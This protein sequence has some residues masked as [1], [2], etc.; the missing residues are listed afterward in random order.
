MFVRSDDNKVYAIQANNGTQ[1]WAFQTGG[2][3]NTSTSVSSDGATVFAGSNDGKVYALAAKPDWEAMWNLTVSSTSTTPERG[4]VKAAL[5]EW[6]LAKS[7]EEA[8]KRAEEVAKAEWEAAREAMATAKRAEEA[9]KNFVCDWCGRS[10][11]KRRRREKG[12]E[13]V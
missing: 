7:A 12:K 5:A 1:K 3:M 6:A 11:Q 8:V 4:E 2:E 13:A 9:A 10:R